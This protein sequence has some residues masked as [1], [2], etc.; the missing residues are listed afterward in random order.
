[1]SDD[2]KPKPNYTPAHGQAEPVLDLSTG[3]VPASDAPSYTPVRR[4]A[5]PVVDLSPPSSAEEKAPL[6]K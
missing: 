5:E 2:P 6:D 1:M 4:E 3:R